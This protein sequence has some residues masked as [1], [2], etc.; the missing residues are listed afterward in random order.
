[1]N[2]YR[3]PPTSFY[4]PPFSPPPPPNSQPAA[5]DGGGK[6]SSF[7]PSLPPGR[8]RFDSTNLSET[9]SFYGSTKSVYFAQSKLTVLEALNEGVVVST[10]A[11]DHHDAG[12][13][14]AVV[15]GGD[16]LLGAVMPRSPVPN[17]HRVVSLSEDPAGAAGGSAVGFGR[18]PTAPRLLRIVSPTRDDDH[19]D[20]DDES[21]H[22]SDDN[23]EG[24]GE[25]APSTSTSSTSR[26]RSPPTINVTTTT[27]R[28]LDVIPEVKLEREK[29]STE[30]TSLTNGAS[31]TDAAPLTLNATAASDVVDT[32]KTTTANGADEDQAGGSEIVMDTNVNN[33]R[34]SLADGLKTGSVLRPGADESTTSNAGAALTGAIAT[35][36]KAPV[37]KEVREVGRAASSTGVNIGFRPLDDFDVRALRLSGAPPKK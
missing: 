4:L 3:T 12:V 22:H 14:G 35:E 37:L 9:S 29:K 34:I 1:M 31:G 26:P 36:K 18:V 30:T 28:P 6:S 8:Q 20:D 17:R 10:V 33:S 11:D 16:R 2:L 19:D 24:R 23:D 27:T 5:L 15:D 25:T 32:L 21:N 13:A 7:L